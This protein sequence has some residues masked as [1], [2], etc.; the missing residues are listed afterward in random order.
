MSRGKPPRRSH[1]ARRPG[2]AGT[3]NP[4]GQ[5]RP[6]DNSAG[7]RRTGAGKPGAS[8]PRADAGKPGRA[9][10]ATGADTGAD[11]PRPAGAGKPSG[12]GRRPAGSGP[13]P[14]VHHH[15]VR[16]NNPVTTGPHSIA[17]NDIKNVIIRWVMHPSARWLPLLLA[18]A[19][20]VIAQTTDPRGP[21]GQYALCLS[22]AVLAVAAGAV[23]VLI[24]R[25]PSVAAVGALSL[26]SVL[27]TVGGWLSFQYAAAHADIDVTGQVQVAGGKLPLTGRDNTVTFALGPAELREPRERLRLTLTVSDWDPS[28]PAC[29][30]RT[31]AT[32]YLMNG[33]APA[34]LP[35]RSGHPLDFVLTSG[36]TSVRIQVTLADKDPG[37]NCRTDV[38]AVSAVLHDS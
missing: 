23:R 22:F 19:A 30:Y 33:G 37:R 13:A 25:T 3:P 29:T 27:A 12:K 36:T 2:S 20:L 24:R 38:R 8:G 5:A 14:E 9:E 32:A 6:G 34:Q 18:C 21:V 15:D 10:A 4:P 35:V 17:A 26:V 28:A 31:S 11:E 16:H 1:S 7:Q